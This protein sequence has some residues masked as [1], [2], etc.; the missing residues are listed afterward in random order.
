MIEDNKKMSPV[1][2]IGHYKVWRKK[3]LGKVSTSKATYQKRVK[4]GIKSVNQ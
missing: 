1:N 4:M 3:E 2:H